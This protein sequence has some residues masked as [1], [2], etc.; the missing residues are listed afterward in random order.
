[1]AFQFPSYYSMPPFFTIQPVLN[2]RK[3]QLQIWVEM[4]LGFSQANKKFEY[5]ITESSK[6]PLFCNAKINRKMSPEGIR[7]IFEEAVLLGNG[8]WTDK[9]K[10]RITI[11]WRRP[12]EW[13]ELIYRWVNQ[14][15]KLN[16]V[17]TVYEI[18][19]GDD[20]EGQ[21]FHGLETRVLLKALNALEK[22][23][24]A[25]VFTGSSDDNLGVKFF[26]I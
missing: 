6:S 9:D 25:Q 22:Q 23:K 18:Q 17:L 7:M 12:E 14:C 1:M 15:G 19:E 5:D 13:G 26:S 8:E 2:T 3:K 20:S 21:E 11:Y 24:K 16:T 10:N 4:I